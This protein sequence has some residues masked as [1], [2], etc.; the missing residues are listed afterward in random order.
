MA[1]RSERRILLATDGSPSADVALDVLCSLHLRP[2][3]RVDVVVVATL[4][5]LAFAGGF[6]ELS[7][8]EDA[9]AETARIA[10]S[11]L[12]KCGVQSG[13]HVVGGPIADSIV[14]TAAAIGAD[15]I[16]AG[17][18]GHGLIVGTLLG[19]IARELARTSPV[20]VLVVRERRV[21]PRRVLVA[22]DGSP[23]SRAAV[24]ALAAVP[25]PADAE[26]VLLHVVPHE[27]GDTSRALDLL[28]LAACR[29]P[30][31]VVTRVE[32]ERGPAAER[33]LA[34]AAALGS[35]LVVLGSR[36]SRGP[37]PGSTAD[38]VLT[39]AHCSVLVARAAERV[40]ARPRV[41]AAAA[42]AGP[43]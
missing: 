34:R 16:V 26:V 29:L 19:S 6:A 37:L 10:V 4:P 31:S 42:S 24:E 41:V 15:L 14:R 18:R 30:A 38:R 17:S 21:A 32:V 2:Q 28:Q 13:S 22:V 3:D 43:S 36:S 12:T 40:P 8:A 27:R 35:D 11:R 5:A 23:D 33:I 7:L 39:G 1:V 20:P 25:L 9:A